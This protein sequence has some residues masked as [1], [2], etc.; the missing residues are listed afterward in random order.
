MFIVDLNQ[1]MLSNL[2]MELGNHLGA[3]SVEETI[4]RHMVL[5]SLR[6]YKVKFGPEYGEM[7]IACDNKNYWRKQIFPYYKASR[8]K[9]QEKSEI[10]W[11]QIFGYIAKIKEELKAHFPYRVI[12]VESAEADDIIATLVMDNQ[13][14]KILILSADKDFVQLQRYKHVKHYDPI[15]KRWL[16]NENPAQYLFEHIIKGDAGDGVPNVLSNDNCFVVGERQKPM[17]K[18]RMN[19]YGEI[20]RQGTMDSLPENVRRNYYRNK[21]LIDLTMIPEVIKLKI[22]DQYISEANKKRDKLL[23]YFM[24]NRLKH[25]MEHISE[26]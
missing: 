4:F 17:T 18:K 2:H 16:T 8:K 5:N 15:R 10:N 25:L 23:N 20:H 13:D 21:Q 1:V 24:A 3:V 12:D 19:A 7:I 6:S 26:F 11:S 14:E 22:R 9:A